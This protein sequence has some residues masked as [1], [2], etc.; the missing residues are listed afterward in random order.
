MCQTLECAFKLALKV[1]TQETSATV[2]S[3]KV[4]QLNYAHRLKKYDSILL[5]INRQCL[6]CMTAK[7]KFLFL[8]VTPKRETKPF[9]HEDW[10]SCSCWSSTSTLQYVCYYYIIIIYLFKVDEIA[11]ILHTH[12]I[13]IKLSNTRILYANWCQLPNKKWS[14]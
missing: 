12:K 7:Y 11:K 2:S 8:A 10:I 13:Y 6:Q 3:D 1:L 14:K 5:K 4:S 9:W